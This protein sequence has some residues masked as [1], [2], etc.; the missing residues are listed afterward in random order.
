MPKVPW[1]DLAGDAGKAH[2]LIADLE[3]TFFGGRSANDPFDSHRLR[4]GV[5]LLSR[6]CTRLKLA[7]TY[8]I[9]TSRAGSGS[10]VLCAF[11]NED[12]RDRVGGLVDARC[13]R[14]DRAEWASRRQ[15]SL[16]ASMHERL[17]SVGGETDNRYAG[18]RRRDRERSAAEQGLR[19]GDV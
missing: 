18:R 7:G 5:N 4:E 19:W 16:T 6:V 8:S 17:I 10:L 9:T 1:A 12:D 2:L 11:E 3:D 14:E 13:T 15:F